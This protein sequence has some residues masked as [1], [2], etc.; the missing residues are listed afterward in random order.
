[1]N[2]LNRPQIKPSQFPMAREGGG[3]ARGGGYVITTFD[4][5]F[6]IIGQ[7]KDL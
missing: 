7:E 4:L 3:G 5:L 6:K 2:E 1:M